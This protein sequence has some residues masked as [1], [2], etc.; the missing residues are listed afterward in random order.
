M[1]VVLEA[2]GESSS[3]EPSTW[4]AEPTT[5]ICRP[6]RVKKNWE[7]R[8][9]RKLFR[10]RSLAGQV[11]Q[12]SLPAVFIDELSQL[13]QPLQVQEVRS[14]DGTLGCQRVGG[15]VGRAERHGGMAAIGQTHDDVRA[16]AVAD[17]DDRQ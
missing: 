4:A 14:G 3:L 5:Q 6:S 16:R 1:G 12:P 10:Q 7:E 17:T 8:L 13:P 9:A 15:V 2:R 11:G